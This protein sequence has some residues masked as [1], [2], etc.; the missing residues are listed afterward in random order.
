MEALPVDAGVG[1]HERRD[2]PVLRAVLG[3]GE[4]AADHQAAT[5]P[6]HSAGPHQL[7]ELRGDRLLDELGVGGRRQGVGSR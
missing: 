4:R 5:V 6:G 3:H 7:H 2:D 1:P